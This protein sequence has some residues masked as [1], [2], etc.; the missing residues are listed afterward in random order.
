[1][2]RILLAEDEAPVREFVTRAL[3]SEGHTVIAVTDGGEALAV[4]ARDPHDLLLADIIMPV[5]DGVALALKVSQDYPDLPIVLMTGFAMEKERAH[6]LH[7]LIR[8]VVSKPFTLDQICD[9]VNRALQPDPSQ[10]EAAT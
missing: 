3:E 1:M 4:L 5:M 8:E 7:T 9:A 10:T 2:A 6:N